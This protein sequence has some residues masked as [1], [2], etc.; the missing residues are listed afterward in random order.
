MQLAK[1]SRTMST[2][3]EHH[4]GPIFLFVNKRTWHVDL[5]ATFSSKLLFHVSQTQCTKRTPTIV[6]LQ[7][8]E[9][10]GHVVCI[11]TEIKKE[12]KKTRTKPDC[13][14]SCV[15]VFKHKDIKGHSINAIDHFYFLFMWISCDNIFPLSV[16]K[17]QEMDKL[18]SPHAR[19]YTM[20]FLMFAYT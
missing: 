13:G 4:G 2:W 10:F 16:C 11:Y 12:K 20:R 1:Y 8:I 9:T 18:R 7:L 15:C 3:T 17:L 14:K 5:T 19:L 6:F